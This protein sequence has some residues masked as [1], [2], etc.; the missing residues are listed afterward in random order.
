M[1]HIKR[2][3]DDDVEMEAEAAG[4]A[5]LPQSITLTQARNVQ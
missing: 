1:D 5:R 2:E 4:A 3:S